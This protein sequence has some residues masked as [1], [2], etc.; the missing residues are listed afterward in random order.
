M[1]TPFCTVIINGQDISSYL[2]NL[3][4]KG[5]LMNI[6]ITDEAGFKSDSVAIT[7]A[8]DGSIAIPPKGSPISVAFGY[9]ESGSMQMGEYVSDI[10]RTSG[11]KD[12]GHLMHIEGTAA[13]M[14]GSLK[15]EQTKSFHE[16]TISDIVSDIAGRNGLTPVVG[17]KLAGIIIPHIDQTHESDM[18]FL[19]R[20]AGDVNATFKIAE[21]KLFFVDRRTGKS[22]SGLLL[23]SIEIPYGGVLDYEWEG[24]EREKFKSVKAWWHDQ[25]EASRKSVKVGSGSPEKTLPRTYPT[26]DEAKRAAETALKDGIASGDTASVTVVGDPQLRA[27]GTQVLNGPQPELIGTWSIQRAEHEFDK[28]GGYLTSTELEKFTS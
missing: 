24:G 14:G 12:G 18:H 23:P 1:Q 10:P 8:R 20:L 3:I 21:N 19:T 22:A 6:T 2:L 27:E 5:R 28:T 15:E 26:K 4:D 13:N 7:I 16:K 25:S 9:R 11:S 17:A